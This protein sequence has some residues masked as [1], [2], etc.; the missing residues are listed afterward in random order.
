M[1]K[2]ISNSSPIIAMSMIGQIHLLDELFDEVFVPGEVYREIVESK[3]FRTHGQQ[4]LKE[5]EKE[6]RELK[7]QQSKNN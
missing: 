5:A 2:A 7:N 4:E 6:V 3:S 1:S